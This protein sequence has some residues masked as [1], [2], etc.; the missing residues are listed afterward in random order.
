MVLAKTLPLNVQ[1]EAANGS[2]VS[3]GVRISTP[4]DCVR[5]LTTC[6]R[7]SNAPITL[8]EYVQQYAACDNPRNGRKTRCRLLDFHSLRL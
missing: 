2:S 6:A 4:V 7:A 8:H 3:Q 5:G 1:G